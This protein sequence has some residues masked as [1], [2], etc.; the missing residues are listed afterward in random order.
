MAKAGLS[1]R[2]G[3]V[4]RAG[5]GERI[6]LNQKTSLAPKAFSQNK[7]GKIEFLRRTAY[8]PSG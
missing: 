4:T 7:T 1:T 5:R 8:Y 6:A 2:R 3:Y